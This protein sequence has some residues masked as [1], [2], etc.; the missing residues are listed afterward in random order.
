QSLLGAHRLGC[1]RVV[2]QSVH[3]LSRRFLVSAFD[4][5]DRILGFDDH[6]GRGLGFR[7]FAFWLFTFAIGPDVHL[8]ARE[9]GGQAGV[10]SLLADGEGQLVLA[11]Y[12][13]GGALFLVDLD[14]AHPSRAQGLGDELRGVL[15]PLYDVDLLAPQFVDDLA[16][17]GAASADGGTLGVDIGVVGHDGDLRAVTGLP[18]DGH[19]LDRPIRQ[20]R[21]LQ[22]QKTADQVG[23]A[24]GDDDLGALGVTPHLDDQCLDPVASLEPLVGDPLGSGH[25]RLGITE[26][27]DGKPIVDLLDDPGDQ[28]PFATL[29][30]VEHLLPLD[31]PQALL[32]HLLGRL[33][34]DPSEVFGRV[35]PL[36]DDVA[37]FIQLLGV[38]DDVP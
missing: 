31:L 9:P 34:G 6:L 30:E 27:E 10:L 24:A 1:D 14:L 16:N 38:D 4:L 33:G 17:A 29:V 20:L 25:D 19:D 18:G 26:I 28:V 22:L 13:G 3:H 2:G 23:M 35:L 11:D 32:D 12:H 7:A 36:G 21:H 37:V 15:A 5:G 8:V